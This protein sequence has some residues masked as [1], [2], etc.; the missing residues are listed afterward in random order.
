MKVTSSSLKP[1]SPR[2]SIPADTFRPVSK[3]LPRDYDLDIVKAIAAIGGPL[4]NGGLNANNLNGN[5][6]SQGLGNFSPKLVSVLRKTPCGGQITIIVDLD[7]TMQDPCKSLILKPGDVVILQETKGQAF[8]RYMATIFKF[9]VT[10]D[11]IR[12][13]PGPALLLSPGRKDYRRRLLRLQ[14]PR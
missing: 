11:F 4:F 1:A 10:A 5:L 2:F 6:S 12:A 8:G 7:R 9:G 14:S 3:S 13:V